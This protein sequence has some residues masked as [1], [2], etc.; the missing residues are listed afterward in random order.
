V[1]TAVYLK[2]RSVKAMNNIR[3]V[4][5]KKKELINEALYFLGMIEDEDYSSE[6]DLEYLQRDL[7]SILKELGIEIEYEE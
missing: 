5:D 3:M 1:P 4:L 6:S 7:D 2:D